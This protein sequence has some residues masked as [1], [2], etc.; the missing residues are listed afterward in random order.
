MGLVIYARVARLLP[1]VRAATA[2]RWPLSLT[3]GACVLRCMLLVV[4]MLG[5]N[6]VARASAD[7]GPAV[8]SD[9]ARY[10]AAWVLDRGDH[11]GRPFAI[12]DKRAARI[13]VFAA[14]GRLLGASAV[15]LGSTPGDAAV[16]DIARRLPSSL[17]VDERTTPA[18]RFASE[19][20][21]NDRGE[22]IVWV[23]Y[24]AA[25]AIHRL[26]PAPLAQRRAQRL[27]SATAS[28]HRISLGCVVVPVAFYEE[29]VAPSL[30][31]R[32]GVVYVLPETRAV[33][34]MFTAL[35]AATPSH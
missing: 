11:Q 15:L 8:L 35:S 26:R 3:T 34:E 9:D 23:D 20:G 6:P 29:V 5:L 16:P 19:P 33:R 17:G 10:A 22:D 12:V 21:Q 18:G 31:R 30:G 25:L 14:D 1:R 32:H 4:A 27:A 28:E 13:H 24:D 7:A 2:R